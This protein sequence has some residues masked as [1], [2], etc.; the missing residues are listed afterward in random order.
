MKHTCSHPELDS[1]SRCYQ[2]GF[3]LLEIMVVIIIIA[4]L[5]IVAVPQY[6][7]AVLKSRYSALL[8]VAQHLKTAQEAYYTGNNYY[9]DD[10]RS[11]DL[12]VPG[13]ITTATTATYGDNMRAKI[14]TNLDE[15]EEYSYVLA[16]KEGL[17]NNYIMYQEHSK[18]YPG[19]IH[20]EAKNGDSYA[21]WLCEKGLAGQ[22]IEQGSI[23]PGYTTYVLSGTGNGTFL[24]ECIEEKE[25]EDSSCACG[26]RTRATTGCDEKTGKWIYG[27]WS[28]CPVKPEEEKACSELGKGWTSGT[29]TRTS[30]CE[31]GSWT[32]PE[33]DETGCTKECTGEAPTDKQLCQEEGKCGWETRE[34][35]C[36]Y[37][38][39]EWI[40]PEWNTE[41]CSSAPAD[42]TRN[43][44]DQDSNTCGI[45]TNSYTCSAQG[46]WELGEWSNT[47][48]DKPA[49]E[50]ATCDSGYTGNKTRSATCKADNTDWEYTGA[51]NINACC[52]NTQQTQT[53]TCSSGCGKQTRTASTCD[54]GTW[55]G[56]GS[57]SSCPTK[58]SNYTSTCNSGQNGSR[59]YTYVCNSAG[60]EWT[61][62]LKSSTC[63]TVQPGGTFTSGNSCTASA[64]STGC[65]DG[66]TFTDKSK[67]YGFSSGCNNNTFSDKAY[68]M[69]YNI[70][71]CTGNTF[72]TGSYCVPVIEG[73]CGE[74]TYE[75]GSYCY[76]MYTGRY[77][78]AGTPTETSGKCWNGSGGRVNCP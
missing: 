31:G 42:P 35:T 76:Q 57:W 19:E 2:Y 26:K 62:K 10:L 29:A 37:K 50:V 56:W 43:C 38:T 44:H 75:S 65:S 72:K 51:Y 28:S 30:Q 58:P 46:T 40:E 69:A 49:D 60:T 18:N 45:Q 8:P 74:S 54:N 78:A 64:S 17:N 27:G 68:C 16:S 22:K 73:A 33:W 3:T 12:D 23:T 1:G 61:T 55:T 14:S 36:N 15:E 24:K 77:C 39:G 21:Q 70:D 34:V 47:C 25:L 66:Y 41:G 48:I 5:A 7:R 4:I 32:E 71:S 59:T 20:C 63:T 52:D 53:Q 11:L 67:C 13:T 6:K 9:S